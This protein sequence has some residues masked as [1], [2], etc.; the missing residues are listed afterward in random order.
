MNENL[1]S[2]EA[3]AIIDNSDLTLS[4]WRKV[5]ELFG[6]KLIADTPDVSAEVYDLIRER[7]AAREAKDFARSDEIRDQLAAQNIL[8]RDTA[9]GSIWQYI[10]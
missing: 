3:F 4:D 2:A 9:N 10:K 1:N 6:L 5:D 8:V 7:E